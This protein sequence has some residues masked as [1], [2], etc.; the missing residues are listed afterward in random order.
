MSFLYK[1]TPHLVSLPCG[2]LLYAAPSRAKIL[3]LDDGSRPFALLLVFSGRAGF[4][5]TS[6]L[7]WF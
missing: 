7:I 4:L 6:V 5:A 1:M 3:S 2:V